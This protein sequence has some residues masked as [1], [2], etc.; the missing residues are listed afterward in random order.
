MEMVQPIH[1]CAAHYQV[2]LLIIITLT[3]IVR[4]TVSLGL[5]VLNTFLVPV[6]T[7]HIF[8]TNKQKIHRVIVALTKHPH[9]SKKLKDGRLR[10][11]EIFL[12]KKSVKSTTPVQSTGH[13]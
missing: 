4:K 10:F 3:T 8:E 7:L 9:K 5:M 1:T 11:C 2:S 13:G 12:K 6:P